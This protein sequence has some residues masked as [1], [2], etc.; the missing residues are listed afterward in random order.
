MKEDGEG[1]PVNAD[2]RTVEEEAADNNVSYADY[3][4][5]QAEKKHALQAAATRKAN[6][7]TKED[8]SWAK[9]QELK[10]QEEEDFV[11]ASAGKTKRTRERKQKEVIDID[12]RFVEAP[13][14][15][16]SGR[17]GRGR[18]D[19]PRRGGERGERGAFRG[20]PRGDGAGRGRGAP[21]GAPRGGATRGG[22][23]RAAAAPIAVNDTNA[24]P[25]LGA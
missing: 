5:Q 7:G 15:R 18:G 4:I 14:Q 1:A 17:G 13:A 19:G 8:K 21:R 16:D 2:G 9:A 10:K 23:P 25:S 6:E 11:A 12:Q 22:A 20:A 24:F 3:L